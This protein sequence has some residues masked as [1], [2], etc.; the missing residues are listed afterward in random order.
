MPLGSYVLTLSCRRETDARDVIILLPVIYSWLFRI[1]QRTGAVRERRICS[2]AV[3]YPRW[4]VEKLIDA[5]EW[6]TCGFHYFLFS[7]ETVSRISKKKYD[8]LIYLNLDDGFVLNAEEEGTF[9][10][11]PRHCRCNQFMRWPVDGRGTLALKLEEGQ[12]KSSRKL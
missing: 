2:Q 1:M 6:L 7:D 8:L 5:A 4:M 9:Q 11:N 3:Y 12:V 10:I